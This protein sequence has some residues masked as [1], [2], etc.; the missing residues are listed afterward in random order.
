LK[1]KGV[2][3]SKRQK[4]KSKRQ[5]QI[6]TT[7]CCNLGSKLLP[8]AFCSLLFALQTSHRKHQV[9]LEKQR[10][11]GKKQTASLDLLLF[12]KLFA[13]SFLGLFS[14]LFND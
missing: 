11:K 3:E 14:R 6:Y 5:V 10:A 2:L 9:F 12:F 8:F 1:K 7:Y 13:Q 4:A